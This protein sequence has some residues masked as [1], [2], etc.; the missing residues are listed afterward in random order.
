MKLRNCFKTT[1]DLRCYLGAPQQDRV[2]A[3]RDSVMSHYAVCFCARVENLI[4]FT[5]PHTFKLNFNT[6]VNI[7]YGH[8]YVFYWA[9]LGVFLL[10]GQLNLN[11][12][13]S[14]H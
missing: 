5:E 8:K 11:I 12:S 1:R 4:Q 14:S 7:N 6:L 3:S 2:L 9:L 13:D 10:L